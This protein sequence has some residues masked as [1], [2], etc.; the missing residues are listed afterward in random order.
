MYYTGSNQSHG[1]GE[2]YAACKTSLLCI[3]IQY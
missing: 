1:D 2:R 3:V